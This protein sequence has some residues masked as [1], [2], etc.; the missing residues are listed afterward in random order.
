MTAIED[1]LQITTDPSD[2]RG[3]SL[4]KSE[5][6]PQG[7]TLGVD[8]IDTLLLYQLTENEKLDKPFEYLNDCFRRN[9]QQKRITKNKP[10]AESLHSTFQE[11]DRL[12]IGYGVVALQ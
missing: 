10:N 4:L 2:T 9:Q 3:Y 8:F 5:E 6:V 12:V 1:I 7:S 11:I